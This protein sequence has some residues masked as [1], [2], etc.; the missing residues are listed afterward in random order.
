MLN[1]Y[2][3]VT[4]PSVLPLTNGKMK[5]AALFHWSKHSSIRSWIQVVLPLTNC[6]MADIM[7]MT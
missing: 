3:T 2:L 5:K 6:L 7:L 1:N 4:L